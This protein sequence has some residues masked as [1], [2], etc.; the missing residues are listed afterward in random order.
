MA[1]GS[2]DHGREYEILVSW[3]LMIP[4]PTGV[5]LRNS[6]IYYVP[7]SE[8]VLPETG[9]VHI[10]P[11]AVN[12]DLMELDT[13]LDK[14]DLMVCRPDHDCWVCQYGNDL[15]WVAGPDF[16]FEDD[17]ST[18]IQ[19]QL[20]TTQTEKLPQKRLEKKYYWDNIGGNFEK[21]E[22]E[23]DFGAFRVMKRSIPEEYAVTSIVTGYY[24]DGKWIWRNYFRPVRKS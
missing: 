7:E 22:V 6:E 9:S 18:Y 17:G 12:D 19:Y 15:Y 24:K 8:Y 4:F 14:G 16:E 21:Y 11:D 10:D 23:G 13:I 1:E 3:P 2:I 5:Y 20:W